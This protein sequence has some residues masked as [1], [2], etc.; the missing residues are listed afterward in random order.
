MQKEVQIALNNGDLAL[1]CELM[2]IG[3]EMYFGMNLLACYA[4]AKLW[5]AKLHARLSKEADNE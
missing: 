2:T 4:K 3:E 1:T 5:T